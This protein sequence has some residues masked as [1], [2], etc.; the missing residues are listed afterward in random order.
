VIGASVGVGS[1]VSVAGTSVGSG[2][3]VGGGISAVRVAFTLSATWVGSAV[4]GTSA[5]LLQAARIRAN[6]IIS[7][8]VIFF[9][10][11]SFYLS[12]VG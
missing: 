9:I 7:Q 10:F 11:F 1:G 2:V 12:V 4:T 8:S 5:V 3:F 6:T